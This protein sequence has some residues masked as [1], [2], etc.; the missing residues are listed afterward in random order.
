MVRAQTEPPKRLKNLTD[1]SAR[2]R[3]DSK[4]CLRAAGRDTPA[5]AL[6]KSPGREEI[7][8]KGSGGEGRDLVVSRTY[9]SPAAAEKLQVPLHKRLTYE[10]LIGPCCQRAYYFRHWEIREGSFVLICRQ[11]PYSKITSLLFIGV[12]RVSGGAASGY[13]VGI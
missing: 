7:G 11:D 10:L 6:E 8:P 12:W 4:R 1:C 9:P 5:P 2:P 13:C 3:C